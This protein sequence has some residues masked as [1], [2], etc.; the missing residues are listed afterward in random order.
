MSFLS[1]QI[2]LLGLLSFAKADV[3]EE[4]VQHVAYDKTGNVLS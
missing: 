1:L 4:V 3:A 2:L